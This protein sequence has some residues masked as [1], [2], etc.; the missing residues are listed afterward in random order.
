MPRRPAIAACVRFEHQLTGIMASLPQI[1]F[2]ADAEGSQRRRVRSLGSP[3]PW[4]SPSAGEAIATDAV[5]LNGR[6]SGDASGLSRAAPNESAAPHAA[7]GGE[8][9]RVGATR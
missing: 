5:E 6:A 3:S 2:P 9:V 1:S 8:R 4:S 7:G